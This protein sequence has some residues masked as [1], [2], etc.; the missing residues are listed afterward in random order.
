MGLA[1]LVKRTSLWC[2]VTSRTYGQGMSV[3]LPSNKIPSSKPLQVVI[4]RCL[5]DFA[6]SMVGSK[7]PDLLKAEDPSHLRAY[8]SE[9]GLAWQGVESLGSCSPRSAWVNGN[10]ASS[11]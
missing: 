3:I 10:R 7:R 9:L 4:R 2:L 1:Q 11:T 5:A 6:A 8:V